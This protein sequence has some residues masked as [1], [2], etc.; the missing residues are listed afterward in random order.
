MMK[1]SF[2][3][4]VIPTH[5]GIIETP[6]KKW[7]V[8]LVILLCLAAAI[9]ITYYVVVNL[10]E[11]DGTSPPGATTTPTPVVTPPAATA[12]PGTEEPT[13]P[14]Q[15]DPIRG[16]SYGVMELIPLAVAL[17]SASVCALIGLVM[18]QV[19]FRFGAV[20][21]TVGIVSTLIAGTLEGV[22][23]GDSNGD[24]DRLDAMVIAGRVMMWIAAGMV[25]L[26]IGVRLMVSYTTSRVMT[27]MSDEEILRSENPVVKAWA[28]T[29]IG[30]RSPATTP[31]EV[32]DAQAEK[33][34]PEL[35]E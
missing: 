31:S 33:E 32:G 5:R 11:G 27:N 12:P 9:S 7:F 20:V 22:T 23:F 17:L 35:F 29:I 30:R 34:E 13:P 16:R 24:P 25:G 3:N 14:R 19:L 10:N 2:I 6:G 21:I 4:Q 26:F 18:Y 8:F 1:K 15:R 28:E